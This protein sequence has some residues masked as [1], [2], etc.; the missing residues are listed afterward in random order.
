MPQWVKD[1]WAG[2]TEKQRTIVIA[3]VSVVVIG[4]LA[5]FVFLGTDYSGF[6]EFIKTV[7]GQ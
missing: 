2:L 6:G 1:F 7:V 4:I 5:S 3:A